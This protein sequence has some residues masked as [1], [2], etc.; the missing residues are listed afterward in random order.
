MLQAVR[1]VVGGDEGGGGASASLTALELL[2][3]EEEELR[4]IVTFSSQL[5]AALGGGLPV[6]KTIEICGAPGVGKTQLWSDTHS[7]THLH[8]HTHS[9]VAV[10]LN[11]KKLLNVRACVRATGC[12]VFKFYS[13]LVWSGSPPVTDVAAA[14]F[15]K[16]L[17]A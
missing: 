2:Q 16:A 8:T 5:D 7:L 4:S 9:S 6:G 15:L 13:A 17:L 12:N 10:K 3:K 14:S 1:R 11:R